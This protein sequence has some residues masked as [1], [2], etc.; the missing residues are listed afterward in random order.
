[1]PAEYI[2]KRLDQALASLFSSYSRACIKTWILRGEV[3][4][5]GMIKKPRDKVAGGE[6]IVIDAKQIDETLLLPEDIQLN[7]VFEDE[8]LL[9]VNKPVGLVV[10]PGAGH[11][12]KTLLNGLLHYHPPLKKL[13]RGGIIH[14]LDKDTSGLLIVAKTLPSMT[15]FVRAMQKRQ[16][17]REYKAIVWGKLTGGGDIESPIGR[18][19]ISRIKMA[20]QPSGRSALTHYHIIERFP[21][22]T[23]VSVQLETGRT[24]QIRVH[25]ASIHHP[26]VGDMTY[27]RARNLRAGASRQLVEQIKQFK[28]QALHADRLSFVHPIRGDE[29]KVEAAIPDDM[30]D[31]L[32]ALRVYKNQFNAE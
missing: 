4:V 9:V 2:G 19:P 23:Y 27:G 32:D 26:L 20:I 17:K 29:V 25:F 14:R 15:A 5:D 11:H 6:T 13:P 3:L 12:S 8:H 1:M 28:H 31:L 16:I 22:H 7:I 24:H 21:L 18:H 10:H 30:T